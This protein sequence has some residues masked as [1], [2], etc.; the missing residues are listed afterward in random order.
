VQEHWC[1]I[2]EE[3][4]CKIDGAVWCINPCVKVLE[5]FEQWS[6]AVSC[7]DICKEELSQSSVEVLV[8]Q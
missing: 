6:R 2:D 1:R 7:K 8:Q 5:Q 3:V 4:W